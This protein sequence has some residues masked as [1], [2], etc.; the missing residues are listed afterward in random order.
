MHGPVS[1]GFLDKRW[2]VGRQLFE[3]N[4]RQFKP[5]GFEEFMISLAFLLALIY[6]V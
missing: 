3:L 5:G 6:E 4:W 1:P 2:V